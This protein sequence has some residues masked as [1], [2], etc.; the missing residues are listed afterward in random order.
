MSAT[1]TRFKWWWGWKTEELERWL[2]EQEAAGWNLDR[3][4]GIGLFFTFRRVEPRR[5]AYR[6]DYQ[7]EL[8]DDYVQL[9]EDAGWELAGQGSGWYYW[10]QAYEDVKPEIYTDVESLIGRNRRQMRILGIIL[11]SQLPI[12]ASVYSRADSPLS[13]GLALV[14]F[15][16]M[17][18]LAFAIFRF[19]Q[20]NRHLRAEL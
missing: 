19:I 11:A 15:S 12:M 20:A 6:V 14:H 3:A 16:V 17:A 8:R 7:T 18:A 5:M 9:F 2:E 4:G 1:K 10:R 13:G